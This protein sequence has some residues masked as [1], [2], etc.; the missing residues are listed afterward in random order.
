MQADQLV[1]RQINDY[2]VHE[3]IGRGGMAAVYR[4]YQTSMSRSVALKV[5]DLVA[6][7][8]QKDEFRQRFAQEAE[9]IAGLEHLHILPVY[10]YGLVEDELAYLSMR[11][12]RGGTLSTAL[13]R[14]P[15]PLD[16]TVLLFTQIARGL[17]YAH[18]R[19]VIHRDIKPSNIL[20]DDDSNAYL[21]DFGLAK[22]LG[23]SREITHSGA[24]IGTPSYMAPE[25]LRGDPV[26]H[27]ADIYSLGVVLYHML[28]GRTPFDDESSN[29]IAVIYQQLEKSPPPPRDVNP[30]IPAQV[31][32]VILTAL[33]KDPAARYTDADV[34]AEALNLAAGS[35]ISTGRF[36]ALA[37]DNRA[38]QPLR[39]PRARQR[40]SRRRLALA[41]GIGLVLLVVL[42]S[43]GYTLLRDDN[44]RP[45]PT[46][47]ANTEG[48]AATVL[49]G[50]R[51]ISRARAALS[52]DGFIA[53]I[54]CNQDSEYHA[55]QARELR[56]F[57]AAYGL[58]LNIYDG[59]NDKTLQI[60]LI[61]RAR[62]DGAA[63]LIVCPLDIELLDQ[64]LASVERA[65]LPLV[66]MSSN[67]PSYGGV[68]LAGDDY[69]MG[70]TAGE[71]AGQI[72]RDELGGVANV[73]IL[74]F[75]DMP[76]IVARADG[77]EDGIL[78]YAPDATIIGRYLGATRE[79]GARSIASLLD[80][81]VE[82]DVIASIND[83][84]ALGAITSLA[85]NDIPPD[86]VI[87]VS[88][89]AEQ[90]ARQFI[91]DGYYLRGSV[92]IGREQFSRAAVNAVVKLL[93]GATVPETIVVP[94]GAV[95]TAAD[96][97]APDEP[98][99]TA[100]SIATEE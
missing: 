12:L 73:V 52:A 16:R 78:E 49:P 65:G 1:G 8:D 7:A 58:R 64:A 94:P 71:F 89:D 18:R 26:D 97:D 36:P 38:T 47:L 45:T 20:L 33:A 96:A 59:D 67:I 48:S 61:E 28:T 100:E 60:P 74:D 79:N 88:V 86:A 87:I 92:E 13:L 25:Q 30:D 93:A 70:R 43:V 11:L 91:R 62:A 44:L 72:I 85:V 3:R 83:A 53:Y 22:L 80:A 19:G 4:A 34:M 69:Q 35:P 98:V 27:R 5:I 46:V 75:P 37:A 54:A 42:V 57:A 31:E 40:M 39:P 23:E 51:D 56:E 14:G 50:A 99:A 66:L 24:I 6:D 90:A 17:A 21:T 95:Y 77:L 9:L 63:A 81:G 29:L 84:G 15:L 10:D 41:L 2:V 68:L 76:V 82:I 55:T 32:T